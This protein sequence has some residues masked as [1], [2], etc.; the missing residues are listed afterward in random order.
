MKTVGIRTFKNEATTLL[1]ANETLVI[2]RH[3]TPVGI[4][5]PLVAKDR[6]TR[7]RSLAE[8]GTYLQAFLT[9]HGLTEDELVA[10]LTAPDHDEATSDAVGS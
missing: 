6:A 7:T 4:Y 1:Q 3:G 9:A 2:E 8:F 10:A 5:I